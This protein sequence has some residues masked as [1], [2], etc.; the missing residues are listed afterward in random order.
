MLYC[1]R[2]EP[3]GVKFAQKGGSEDPDAFH[4]VVLSP[5]PFSSAG[6]HA[7][8]RDSAGPRHAAGIAEEK[9]P[10]GTC[11]AARADDLD[12]DLELESEVCGVGDLV[13][14][15]VSGCVR[16][17]WHRGVGL[18]PPLPCQSSAQMSLSDRAPAAR[19]G[20]TT[21]ESRSVDR[22]GVSASDAHGTYKTTRTT[23]TDSQIGGDVSMVAG[24]EQRTTT[25]II[26]AKGMTSKG[27]RFAETAV[28]CRF[29]RY[30]GTSGHGCEG[31]G[32]SLFSTDSE[33]QEIKFNTG[34]FCA[35]YATVF[36]LLAYRNPVESLCYTYPPAF[37][38]NKPSTIL[39]ALVH[40]LRA[41]SPVAFQTNRDDPQVLT[42]TS[43]RVVWASRNW[44]LILLYD[45]VA[46]LHT[47]HILSHKQ[48]PLFSSHCPEVLISDV[49]WQDQIK[50]SE[51]AVSV[52]SGAPSMCQNPRI[53]V[54]RPEVEGIMQLCTSLQVEGS[55]GIFPTNISEEVR[56]IKR[57]NPPVGLATS[58]YDIID[59]SD[60]SVQNFYISKTTSVEAP[61]L[62]IDVQHSDP[63]ETSSA[64][65]EKS[66]DFSHEYDPVSSLLFPDDLRLQEVCNLLQSSSRVPINDSQCMNTLVAF[67]ED[68]KKHQVGRGAFVLST[69][70][71]AKT[72]D[73]TLFPPLQLNGVDPTSHQVTLST[74]HDV[75]WPNFHNGVAY[76]LKFKR[77][78]SHF[79]NTKLLG[80][81]P[82]T[83]SDTHAGFLYGLGLQGNLALSLVSVSEFLKGCHY[84]TIIAILLGLSVSKIGSMD[85][86]VFRA[87]SLHLPFS[88]EHSTQNVLVQASAL[89]G[90][91]LLYLGSGNSIVGS[92]LLQQ[93]DQLPPTVHP[94]QR[95][96]W[97]LTAGMAYGLAM[98]GLGNTLPN[99]QSES[100]HPHIKILRKR[101][102]TQRYNHDPANSLE[103]NISSN[104]SYSG[105][106]FALG[107]MFLKTN[108]VQI[109]SLL[110]VQSTVALQSFRPD[111]LFITVLMHSLILWDTIQAST[112]WVNSH[113]PDGPSLVQPRHFIVAGRCLALALKYAGT[114]L[115]VIKSLLLSQLEVM[116]ADFKSFPNESPFLHNV[117]LNMLLISLAILM[118]GTGDLE[119]LRHLRIFHAKISE[120]VTYGDHMARHLALG[121]LFLGGGKFNLSTSCPSVAAIVCA[122]YPIF[123]SQPN[124]NT[125][126]LQALRHLYVIASESRC[127][128]PCDVE[129]KRVCSAMVRVTLKPCHLNDNQ[130]STV[131]LRGPCHL[132]EFSLIT[133]I[134]V[135]SEGYWGHC[136]C[137]SPQEP[138]GYKRFGLIDIGDGLL[139]YLKRHA[140]MIAA[141]P[142][143][144][145]SSLTLH[146][147]DADKEASWLKSASG[148]DICIRKF[149]SVCVK[150]QTKTHSGR[151]DVIRKLMTTSVHDQRLHLLNFYAHLW[152]C[153]NNPTTTTPQ[154]LLEISFIHFLSKAYP[155]LLGTLDKGF[156]R[157]AY[158]ALQTSLP[159][160][161]SSFEAY[162]SGVSTSHAP[163]SD[164]RLSQFLALHNAPPLSVLRRIHQV[165]TTTAPP[166]STQQIPSPSPPT[167]HHQPILTAVTTALPKTLVLMSEFPNLDAELL[168]ELCQIYCT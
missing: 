114:G 159:L 62:K 119:T 149:I 157:W 16:R 53:Y 136:L 93:L 132:P 63:S 163:A 54:L 112:T 107:L 118:A 140:G 15:S 137:P 90:V 135:T 33:D 124:D 126:H 117:C 25:E 86:D 111:L 100:E 43:K 68:G 21:T 110:Q 69:S 94:T 79:S 103:C 85:N 32:L 46:Q 151:S 65:P 74:Q 49:I 40:P 148:M 141:E 78:C 5:D 9:M 76:G 44:P 95:E 18:P 102:S 81:R 37:V 150:S 23:A 87:L 161:R 82:H 24:D 96:M 13:V 20:S 147:L 11:T 129:T 165:L 88:Q 101:L 36:G 31:D 105:S 121:F 8:N 7:K 34:S 51:E 109:A 84:L 22:C 47:L 56:A 127:I 154:D 17:V 134:D 83:L 158:S 162:I 123:P 35:I 70:N 122:L 146:A 50:S 156:L 97:H 14:W 125:Y 2:Y 75:S 61:W 116:N 4:G 99:T 55:Q 66:N 164:L 10:P 30:I 155:I 73:T 142:P 144:K 108:N 91:G 48:P 145:Y 130:D 67:S 42:D 92:L 160:E 115:Q 3:T 143:N 45:K 59:R 104:A 57:A 39:F 128:I 58:T 64:Q 38:K 80:T 27:R 77:R 71:S 52:F 138:E 1:V 98:L 166:P 89:I 12:L 131:L 41:L 168:A 26:G 153:V 133:K 139:L 19:E 167:S 106:V 6:A 28:W 60:L 113:V 120:D 152:V 29:G 72:E